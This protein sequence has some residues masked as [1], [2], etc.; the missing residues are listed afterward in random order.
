MGLGGSV[1]LGGGSLGWSP[2]DW[3]S[4]RL[5]VPLGVEESMRLGSPG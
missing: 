2:R 1:G 5:G 3:G 4:V